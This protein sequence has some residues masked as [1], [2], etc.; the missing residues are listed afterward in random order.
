MS[1]R[2]SYVPAHRLPILY[3]SALSSMT[4]RSLQAR[5]LRCLFRSATSLHS[6]ESIGAWRCRSKTLRAR[7]RDEMRCRARRSGAAACP[8]LRNCKCGRDEAENFIDRIG[9]RRR[10][11]LVEFTPLRPVEFHSNPKCFF[12]ATQWFFGLIRATTAGGWASV[13][14]PALN[15]RANQNRRRIVVPRSLRSRRHEL[16]AKTARLVVV[17]S[18]FLMLITAA[19][20]IGGRSVIGPMLEKAMARAGDTHRKGAIVFTMPDGTFC[21]HLAFDNKT[22][23]L[24]ESTVLQCP[25]AR[26]REAAHPP[27]GF[28][29]GAH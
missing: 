27:S 11:V 9:R 23:E 16:R 19:V 21:R 17:L 14:V 4:M 6:I 10:F 29:W 25:E 12:T 18:L 2:I 24:T 28:A 26:P 3:R 5:A 20:F 13:T 1:T 8:R 7:M 15:V 22:A